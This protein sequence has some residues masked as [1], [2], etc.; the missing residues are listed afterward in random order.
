MAI[1]KHNKKG[2]DCEENSSIGATSYL[3]SH[4]YAV[5]VLDGDSIEYVNKA[6]TICALYA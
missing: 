1:L 5:I 3:V 6:K 4:F 2:V